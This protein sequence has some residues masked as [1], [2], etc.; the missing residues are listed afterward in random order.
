MTVLAPSG[1]ARIVR[2]GFSRTPSHT[3]TP[4]LDPSARVG[5]SELFC[6]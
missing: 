6:S 1:I 2:V 4:I 5:S 3:A